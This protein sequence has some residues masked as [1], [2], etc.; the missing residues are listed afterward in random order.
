MREIIND[1]TKQKY[2]NGKEREE[3]KKNESLPVNQIIYLLYIIISN[4]RARY[5]HQNKKMC[6]LKTL[7]VCS[8]TRV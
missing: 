8:D 3:L 5:L 7:N 2:E 1:H 4:F 6:M